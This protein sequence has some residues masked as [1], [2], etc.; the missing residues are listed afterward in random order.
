MSGIVRLEWELD[1]KGYDLI[2]RQD[3]P[4]P[5]HMGILG[6]EQG[7]TYLTPRGGKIK[8]YVLEGLDPQVYVQVANTPCTPEGVQTLVNRWGLLT[9]M[10]EPE[11]SNI[12][13]NIED[14]RAG[15]ELANEHRWTDLGDRVPWEYVGQLK[16]R[17]LSETS[18][19]RVVLEPPGLISFCWVQLM[20]IVAGNTEIRRCENCGTFMPAEVAPKRGRTRRHCSANCRVAAH[21]KKTKGKEK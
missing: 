17:F 18:P 5:P 7:G 20:Q 1:S 12:D 16:V 14:L 21:R 6:G 13:S 3:Q 15:V 19:P 8:R 9:R 4:G 10:R 2:E 11:L